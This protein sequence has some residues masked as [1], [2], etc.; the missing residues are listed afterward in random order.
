MRIG[1]NFF[2]GILL[3]LLSFDSSMAQ[4]TMIQGTVR[5]AETKKPA[6]YVNVFFSGSTGGVVTD[7]DGNYHIQTAQPYT[8]L[9]F[10]YLGYKTVIKKIRPGTSTTIDVF[11]LVDVKVLDEVV[12]KV[13]KKR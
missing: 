6:P 7:L 3:L 11:L 4:T 2:T 8:E 1:L 12:V 9:E 5:D 10:S 13:S